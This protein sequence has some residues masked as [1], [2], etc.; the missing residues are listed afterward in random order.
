MMLKR[1]QMHLVT[2]LQA[3]F[4]PPGSD[5]YCWGPTEG[6]CRPYII[7]EGTDVATV[8][9]PDTGRGYIYRRIK[10]GWYEEVRNG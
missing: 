5:H 8:V 9:C 7:T 2:N 1:I 6:P 3:R 4:N 10:G